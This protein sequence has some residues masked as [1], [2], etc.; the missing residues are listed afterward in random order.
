ME[1]IID[2]QHL[3]RHWNRESGPHHQHSALQG[4]AE[5]LPDIPPMPELF[6]ASTACDANFV[7]G[8]RA[9]SIF[10]QRSDNTLHSPR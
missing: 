10:N 5:I 6:I 7:G 2:V 3:H 1:M 9:Y 4:R 8:I